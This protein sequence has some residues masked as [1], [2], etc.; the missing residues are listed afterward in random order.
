MLF[1]VRFLLET[2][3]TVCLHCIQTDDQTHKP[4]Q[5]IPY[6]KANEQHFPLLQ[7]VNQLVISVNVPELAHILSCKHKS[8]D[9]YGKEIA[10]REIFIVNDSQSKVPFAVLLTNIS[11]IFGL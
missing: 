6:V 4:L 7:A 9:I 1:C 8:Q 10:E 3:G 5:T 2:Y 11:I